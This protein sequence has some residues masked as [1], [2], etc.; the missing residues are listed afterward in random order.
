MIQLDAGGATAAVSVVVVAAVMWFAFVSVGAA[1]NEPAWARRQIRRVVPASAVIAAAGLV[2][3]LWV[4]PVWVGLAVIYVAAVVGFMARSVQA[5]LRRADAIGGAGISQ[6]RRR[7]L[8]LRTSRWMWIAAAV[9]V[10]VTLVDWRWRGAAA[11]ADGV[12]VAVFAVAA[13]RAGVLADAIEGDR[14]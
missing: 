4:R 8:L 5:G 11:V 9:L 3:L 14:A 6:M 13:W 1:A 7:L 2:G 12:L 10:V